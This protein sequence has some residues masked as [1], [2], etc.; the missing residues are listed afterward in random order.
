MPH[1]MDTDGVWVSDPV[2]GVIGASPGPD[3]GAVRGSFSPGGGG[4]L[5]EGG[6][7]S[8]L[9]GAE[10]QWGNGVRGEAR[11]TGGDGSAAGVSV[12]ILARRDVRQVARPGAAVRL[13]LRRQPSHGPG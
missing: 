10:S 5:E 1:A 9:V 13:V 6:G 12:R 4:G 3:P 11:G 8:L 2:V 7:R